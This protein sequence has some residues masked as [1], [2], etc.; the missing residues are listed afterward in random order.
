MG[1]RCVT[2]NTSDYNDIDHGYAATIHKAQGVTVDSV[3]VLASRYL[4]R[5][6]TYVAMSRH[7]VDASLYVSREDF[8]DFND[9]TR[10]LG[11][12]AAKDTTLDYCE[13]PQEAEVRDV[14][15]KPVPVRE[16]PND[17]FER[18]S[19]PGRADLTAFKAKFEASQPEKAAKLAHDTLPAAEKAALA[20][21]GEHQRLEKAVSQS[22]GREK[23]VNQYRLDKHTEDMAKNK[24]MRQ[25][26]EKHAPKLAKQLTTK[27]QA[28]SKSHDKDF[29]HSL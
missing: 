6:S 3:H 23:T 21:I 28:L 14:I 8:P 5:H 20:A 16:K 25:H 10:V 26:L 15:D 2:F 19:L 27:S 7:R 11:R 22:H 12:E 13:R 17:R 9:M 29:G 18:R 4:D 24:P 1:A